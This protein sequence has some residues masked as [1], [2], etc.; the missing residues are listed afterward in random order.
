MVDRVASRFARGLASREERK[1]DGR[2]SRFRTFHHFRYLYRVPAAAAAAAR[3]QT[4]F[5]RS[6]REV[7]YRPVVFPEERY[8]AP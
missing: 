4:A 3:I 6:A 2:L 5:E 1:R 7:L 8:R